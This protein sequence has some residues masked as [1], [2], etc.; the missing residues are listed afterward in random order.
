MKTL[1][2]T[3]TADRMRRSNID[4]G[5]AAAYYDQEIGCCSEE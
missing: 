5:F 4:T 3:A 2:K 1:K